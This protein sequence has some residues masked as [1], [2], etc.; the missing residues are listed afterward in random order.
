MANTTGD[1]GGSGGTLSISEFT[2]NNGTAIKYGLLFST[3]FGGAL[4]AVYEGVIAIVLA[5]G[6]LFGRL[7]GGLT[8]FLVE[9]I[10]LWLAV[11]AAIARQSFA[12]LEAAVAESGIVAAVVALLAAL[13]IIY[14]AR[15]G[16]RYVQ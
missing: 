7:V 12:P 2:T 16:V 1:G 6:Q 14:A 13:S 10:G 8:A 15:Q 5:I 3:I 11:P 4:L 9:V